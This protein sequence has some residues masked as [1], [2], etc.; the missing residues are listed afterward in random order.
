MFPFA[1]SLSKTHSRCSHHVSLW[2]NDGA[3]ARIKYST[4]A[5]EDASSTWNGKNASIGR[6]LPTLSNT[7]TEGL[8]Y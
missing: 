7:S 4:N 6:E 3:I 8:T 1:A 5:D 2:T